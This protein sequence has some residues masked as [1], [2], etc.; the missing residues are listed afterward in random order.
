MATVKFR[1]KYYYAIWRDSVGRQFNRSTGETNEKKAQ[2]IA[3]ALEEASRKDSS[4]KAQYKVLGD[5]LQARGGCISVA[6][7]V[8]EWLKNKQGTTKPG[9]IRFYELSCAKFLAFL[10]SKADSP[11][12]SVSKQELLTYRAQLAEVMSAKTAQH[13]FATVK[14]IFKSA[15]EDDVLDKNPAQYTKALQCVTAGLKT[16]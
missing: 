2:K 10:G 15:C 7:Y 5:M 13:H 11:L 9:S 16:G 4:A 3:D 6:K 12:L 8:A 1:G 14:S